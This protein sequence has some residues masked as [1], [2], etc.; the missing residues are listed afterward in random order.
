LDSG[1]EY[2][3]ISIDEYNEL[4][5]AKVEKN[6][7]ARELRS[8]LKRDE[9]HRLNV[10]TQANLNRMIMEEKQ[11][12]ETYVHMLLE[13]TPNPI[14]VFDANARFL[15]GSKP[16]TKIIDID[17]VTLLRGR[18]LDNIVEIYHPCVLTG[19]VNAQ[20]KNIISGNGG[21]SECTFEITADTRNYEVSLHPFY[22]NN[23]TLIGVFIFMHDITALLKAKEIAE[24]SSRAKSE[25]LSNMS[26]EIRTPMNAIIGMTSIGKSADDAE[27]M[28]YCFSKIEAASN[29]LL[30]IINDI[31]DMSKIEAGKFELSEEEFDFEKMLQMLVNVINFRV[32]EK[33][34]KLTVHIEK[35]IPA[36]LI[37]DSQRL[38]QIITNLLGNA[39]KFTPEHGSINLDARLLREDGDNSVIQVSVTDTGIGITP[40]Q[41][42]R[43]FQSFQQAESSTTRKF[44]GTGLGLSISKRIVEMMGGRIWVESEPDKGSVFSFTVQMKSGAKK[45]RALPDMDINLDNIRILVVDDAPDVLT[46]FAKIMQEYG[47]SCDTAANW[48]DAIALVR[49][50]G[51]YNIYFIDW[52]MPGVDGIEL[53]RKLKNRAAITGKSVVIMISAAEFCAV[54][55]EAKEVGIDRFL[56][57]PLFPPTIVDIINE[58]VGHRQKRMTKA[59][60][61]ADINFKGCHILLAEDVEINREIVQALLEPTQLEID[62]AENGVEA[63]K[64]FSK[65][66]G[67]YDV[68]LMDLQMPEMD[69]YEAARR[70]RSFDAPKAKTIP[71]IA[72]TANVFKEDIEKCLS[73]GMNDH[74]GKPIDMG[75]LLAKFEQYLPVR[76]SEPNQTCSVSARYCPV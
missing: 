65:N 71:I 46:F 51:A 18:H 6:R 76:L 16:I 26:H 67:L 58:R 57:K 40:E 23:G 69:G 47:I 45:N 73:S 52:K 66:P 2:V 43:L 15:L 5:A 28:K 29:H 74:L 44:G 1:N 59:Q 41:Q 37:G 64:K 49:E 20:I 62:C 7:L 4:K 24:Q 25:F 3:T 33:H 8:L 27:R 36:T 21:N 30:G 63:F 11:K 55:D 35:D 31:L 42:T 39:V 70:I 60:P 10:D 68:I 54:K 9:V 22:H 32:D 12:Q 75:E 56:S 17:D 72:L 61:G 14:F 13:L 50:N 38:A 53:T 34:Q 48:K 19:E